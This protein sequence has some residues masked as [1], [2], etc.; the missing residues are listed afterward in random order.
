VR[1]WNLFTTRGKVT[2]PVS[3]FRVKGKDYLFAADDQAVYV[4]DRTGNIRVAHQEPLVKAQGSA[5]RLTSGSEPAIIFSAPDGKVVRLMF[6]GT[7]KQDTLKGV[8]ATARSEFAD[9]DGDNS[10]DHLSLDRGVLK[11]FDGSGSE[12]W[13]YNT[14][15]GELVGPVVLPAGTGERRTAV[16]DPAKRMVHLVGRNGTPVTGFPHPS[17]PWFNIGRVTGKSTWNLIVSGSETWLKNYELNSAS[18]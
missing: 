18:K 14:G 9:I 1:G 11:A 6:D 8:S 2:E 5:A 4:L 7:V 17:G 16:Y 13:S 10:T 3:F 15:T 12:M